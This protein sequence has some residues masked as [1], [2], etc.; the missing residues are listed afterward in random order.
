[1]HLFHICR[2]STTRIKCY[3]VNYI[4]NYKNEQK[5]YEAFFFIN[6]S[7]RIIVYSSTDEFTSVRVEK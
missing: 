6:C 4:Q 3:N 7:T 1:M 5:N 2:K